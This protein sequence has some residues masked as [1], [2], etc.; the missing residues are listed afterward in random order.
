[1]SDGAGIRSILHDHD[2][3]A[4]TVTVDDAAASVG[5]CRRNHFV[6]CGFYKGSGSPT[7]YTT[8]PVLTQVASRSGITLGH[9]MWK[10]PAELASE[11]G[12]SRIVT[13]EVMEE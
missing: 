7:F 10:T 6:L 1:M 5:D 13:V 11:M 8:L 4:A 12:V 2:L 9:R 3:Y